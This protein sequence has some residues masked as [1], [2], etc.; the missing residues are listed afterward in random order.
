MLP[1]FPKQHCPLNASQFPKQ[2][3]PLNDSQFPK[4]HCPL[5]VSTLCP[6]SFRYEYNKEIRLSGAMQIKA[7]DLSSF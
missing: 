3:C 5:N 7:E 4:Q 6:L 1:E 2:H